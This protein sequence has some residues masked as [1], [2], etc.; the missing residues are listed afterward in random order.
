MGNLNY[1]R[2]ESNSKLMFI[3]STV[4]NS[5]NDLSLLQSYKGMIQEMVAN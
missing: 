4:V 3:A 2:V 1:Q 5:C